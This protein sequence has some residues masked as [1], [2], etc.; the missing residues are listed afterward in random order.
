MSF[1]AEEWEKEET[2]A[3]YKD[4][5][6]MNTIMGNNYKEEKVREKEE[7]LKRWRSKIKIRH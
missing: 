3:W 5:H 7:D 4:K 6:A 1:K 2:K